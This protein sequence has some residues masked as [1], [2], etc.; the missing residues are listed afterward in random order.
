MSFYVRELEEKDFKNNFPGVL[1]ELTELGEI[2]EHEAVKL[3]HL[4]KKK[5][6][7][8]I[9][10]VLEEG[11]EQILGSATIFFEYKFIHGLSVVGHIEDVVIGKK[12]RGRGL[13]KMLV[14][15][16]IE[17]S[18]KRNCYKV[19]LSAENKNIEFYSKLGFKKNEITMVIYHK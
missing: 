18:K 2:C 14:N 3:F 13:G 16:L 4:L 5:E 12:F 11:N 19:I 9:F 6:D 15:R 7:Y 8:K 1:A 17:E 10:V